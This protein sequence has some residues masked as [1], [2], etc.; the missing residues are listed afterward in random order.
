MLSQKLVVTIMP[1]YILLP[2]RTFDPYW[3]LDSNHGF[4]IRAPDEETAR[5]IADENAYDEN[6]W[7]KTPNGPRWFGTPNSPRWSGFEHSEN[8]RIRPWLDPTITS[9]TELSHEGED[10]VVMAD[11]RAG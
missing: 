1:L 9:C 6:R 3:D 2:R 4:V 10:Q 5:K 7:R 8:D 11:Y